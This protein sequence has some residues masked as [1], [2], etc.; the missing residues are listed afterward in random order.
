[1]TVVLKRTMRVTKVLNEAQYIALVA[2]INHI[3]L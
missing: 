1:M 2:T 3:Q